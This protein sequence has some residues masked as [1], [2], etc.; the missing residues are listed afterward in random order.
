MIRFYNER[1]VLLNDIEIT[2]ADEQILKGGGV[3][4][5]V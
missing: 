1:L 5:I 4:G 3:Y 2:I